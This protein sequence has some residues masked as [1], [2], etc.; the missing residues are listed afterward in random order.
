MVGRH[1]PRP[2][3]KLPA[4]GN[5]QTCWIWGRNLVTETLRAGRWPILELHL[6]TSLAE[7]ESS[8]VRQIASGMQI[9]VKAQ[10]NDQLLQL[11]RNRDHQ[12]FVAKM[13]E[14][15]YVPLTELLDNGQPSAQP[16]Y[17]VCDSIQ[18][19]FNLGAMLR[20]AEALRVTGVIIGQRDQ[21][22]VTSHV[23]RASAGAVNH[24][25]I[26]R[27]DDLLETARVLQ[28][29]GTQLVGAS[30]KAKCPLSACD[31]RP[32]TAVVIGNEGRG[33]RAELWSLCDQ[34]A[35]I[36][37]AGRVASLNAAVASGIVLYEA[38]RQRQHDQIGP[39]RS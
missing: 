20:T 15:P 3:N 24:L 7:D 2:S 38:Q 23:A 36:P 11:C 4:L 21:V 14:Y 39:A 18:D 30:E 22:G 35:R 33:V 28:S 9:T 6:A 8:R 37:L 31:F 32:S 5:H 17:V 25:A 16:L 29:R 19:P 10:T 12:G 26:T 1:N 34:H 13:A 27:T